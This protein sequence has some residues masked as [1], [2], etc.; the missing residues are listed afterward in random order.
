MNNH[1]FMNRYIVQPNANFVFQSEWYFQ[2]E[3][4]KWRDFEMKNTPPV[5]LLHS[6]PNG[7]YR[8]GQRPDADRGARP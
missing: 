5:G 4:E 1:N 8:K 6:V 7:Q 3:C 2:K